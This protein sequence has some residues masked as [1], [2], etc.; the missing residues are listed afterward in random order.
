MPSTEMPLSK[1]ELLSLSQHFSQKAIRAPVVVD[2]MSMDDPERSTKICV[3]FIE[4]PNVKIKP[5]MDSHDRFMENLNIK[6]ETSDLGLQ[7][8]NI[9]QFQVLQPANGSTVR[10]LPVSSWLHGHP[11][12]NGYETMPSVCEFNVPIYSEERS[13]NIDVN[14]KKQQDLEQ[15][16]S[17]RTEN[18]PGTA[19]GGARTILYDETS[20]KDA[21][22]LDD[23]GSCPSSTAGSTDD[24]DATGDDEEVSED[25]SQQEDQDATEDE[26]TATDD[27]SSESDSEGGEDE[28]ESHGSSTELTLRTV[29]GKWSLLVDIIRD[30]E[31]HTIGLETAPRRPIVVCSGAV[32]TYL[33]LN[34]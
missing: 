20:A 4:N 22:N 18:P 5:S 6:F 26:E 23:E 10:N 34:F 30:S 33:I 16:P 29:D 21:T 9:S 32:M 8:G 27:T 11:E 19:I 25:T 1:A 7:L 24:A 3:R 13:G 12:P 2:N 28:E 31:V 14:V 15:D 17:P